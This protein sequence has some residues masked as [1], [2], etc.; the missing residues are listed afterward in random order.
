MDFIV[1]EFDM[2]LVWSVPLL[3][4]NLAPIR[5]GLCGDNFLPSE[6]CGEGKD[7]NDDFRS[8]CTIKKGFG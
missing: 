8:R 1:G 6:L 7:D 3:E 5:T 4:Y 2:I